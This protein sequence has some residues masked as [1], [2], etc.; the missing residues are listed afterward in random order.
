MKLKQ[1][2][3]II[4]ILSLYTL[5]GCQPSATKVA[6][7]KLKALDGII[8]GEIEKG[9]FP[10]AVVLVGRGQ[11]TLYRRAFG[12]QMIT[13]RVEPM[14]EDTVFDI[15]SLTKPVATAASIMILRDRGKIRLADKVGQYLPAF[16][17]EGKEETQIEHILTHTSGLPAY[18]TAS[19]LK[20]Q[21]GSPCPDKVIEKICSLKA[22]SEPGQE[23]RYSCLGYITLAKIV[24]I[25]SGKPINQFA[26]ENIFGPL[27]MN[28]TSYNPPESWKDNIAATE[29]VNGT[30]LRGTV[31][32]P[33]AQL[34]DGISGNAGVFS[35]ADDLETFCRML[36]N[37]GTYNGK[38]ILSPESV[39]LLT[40]IASHGR[41]CGFDVQSSYAWI[42]G[43]NA[44]EGTFCHSGYT[45]TSIVCDPSGRIFVIILT[46]RA[47]P[48]DKGTVKPVRTKVADIAFEIPKDRG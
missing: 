28:R 45:G 5:T 35:T 43:N 23:M 18:T 3:T 41:A 14:N 17:C 31:H 47:H 24:Q 12:N 9:N 46:N 11:K 33:L 6:R 15:A 26:A 10:G 1:V 20:G 34:M 21:F 7:K 37:G 30:P 38:Q 19:E 40:T 22:M 32:D 16:A 27:N 13:P 2:A 42:K 8:D 39:C 44:P 36:L 29:V 48:D 4:L 25:V